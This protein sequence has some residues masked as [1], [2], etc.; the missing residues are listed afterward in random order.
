MALGA[1]GRA[2]T[3]GRV[4]LYHAAEDGRVTEPPAASRPFGKRSL[5]RSKRRGRQLMS[6]HGARGEHADGAQV[7]SPVASIGWVVR[8][9]QLPCPPATSHA[10][11]HPR[12]LM[13]QGAAAVRPR[14]PG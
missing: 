5:T 14:Q 11:A 7:R 6:D 13:R 3:F 10:E 8:R 1:Y 2:P 4:G 12:L 9:R